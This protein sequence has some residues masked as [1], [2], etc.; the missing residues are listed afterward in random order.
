M[1]DVRNANMN[2]HIQ[3][4]TRNHACLVGEPYKVFLLKIKYTFNEI[5][6]EYIDV[7]IKI[8][9]NH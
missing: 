8:S 9:R 4:W 2:L 3:I 7:I 6:R 1:M 5:L